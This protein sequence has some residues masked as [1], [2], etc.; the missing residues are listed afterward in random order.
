MYLANKE[1]SIMDILLGSQHQFLSIK[2]ISKELDVSVRTVQR[3]LKNVELTLKQFNL[4]LER[5]TNKGIRISGDDRGV[6]KLKNILNNVHNYELT[7]EER[8]NIIFYRLITSRY[9]LKTNNLSKELS[10]S[11]TTLMQDLTLLEEI[12]K[13]LTI[14]LIRK[15]G[16]GI[17][18]VGREKDIRLSFIN[19]LMSRIEQNSLYFIK[20]NE[21]VFFN[22]N[23]RVLGIMDNKLILSIEKP[24]EKAL[25]NLPFI[26]TGYAKL[27]MLLY[28][29]LSV[30]RI[31]LNYFVK[32]ESLSDC[33][34]NPEYQTSFI[35]YKH[36]SRLISRDIPIGEVNFFAEYLKGAKRIR[37]FD[38]NENLDINL[39]AVELI[40]LILKQTGYQ[41][42]QDKRFMDGLISHL[43]P[44]FNRVKNGIFV[45]NPIK[46][47][48]KKD[49]FLLFNSLEG[50]LKYKFPDLNF[51]ED[52]IGFL[53]IHFASAI[54][55]LKQTPKI[56]TLVV[57]TNGI[58]ASRMLSKR[59]LDNFPQLSIIEESSIK[60]L[61]KINKDDFDI[62]ISTVRIY[63]AN[64]DYILV[65]PMITD[66]D[67]LNIE[68]V[69]NNKL[70]NGTKKN[71]EIINRTTIK[72]LEK[73]GFIE[74]INSTIN[75]ILKGFNLKNISVNTLGE[76]LDIIE[77][78]LKENSISKKGIIKELILEKENK[79]GSGIPDSDL[80]LLHSR[81][82]HIHKTLFRIYRNDKKIRVK[83]MDS[84]FQDVS[85]FLFLVA[86]DNLNNYQLDILSSISVSLLESEN[87]EAFSK[88][89]KDKI[90]K[91]L[92]N[93]LS[94]RYNE[95]LSNI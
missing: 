27:E 45:Y 18:L 82:S 29:A 25:E 51:S 36:I 49:Y 84:N 30:E 95:L 76:V 70:L 77:D 21:F 94:L 88:L 89:H 81:N 64:F 20:E 11:N 74:S 85:T 31:R 75:E 79:I 9:P 50:I 37:Q 19:L 41:F 68:G 39:L 33:T 12:L 62:I 38:I 23:D 92:E 46:D 86:N 13:N 61:S 2:S 71:Q 59:L 87:M 15:R 10:I 35:I 26:L 22:E 72:L 1:K 4:I 67:K 58:G 91:L 90:Y 44:L 8:I 24:L 57:C 17:E 69:I 34:F 40:E 28:L 73:V 78:D 93:I 48:I 3:E 56:S 43:E 42:K 55:I 83:G 47:E 80:I 5:V 6:E 52:E 54:P 53:T 66:E 14:K 16:Y 63:N 60:G 32:P 65:N 7:Q